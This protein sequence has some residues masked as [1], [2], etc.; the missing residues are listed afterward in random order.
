MLYKIIT[1][2]ISTE[3]LVGIH[4]ERA[5]VTGSKRYEIEGTGIDVAWK[6]FQPQT[7]RK[8]GTSNKAVVY[9]PGWG[10]NEQA[11]AI[12][13]L[14]QNLAD[15]S[16]TTT[17]AL[18]TRTES[19]I[20]HSLLLEAR[21]DRQFIEE[22]GIE[23]I[24]IVGHSQ[25]GSQAIHL[26]S[27]LQDRM[28]VNSLILLDA[29]G[30]YTQSLCELLRNYVQEIFNSAI[31]TEH[32]FNIDQVTLLKAQNKQ[33]MREGIAEIYRQMRL[34][35][36]IDHYL[37][38]LWN[39][40]TEICILNPSVQ[41]IRVPIV[42][43]HGAKDLIS[44]LSKIIP[45]QEGRPDSSYIQSIHEREQFL[46]EHLFPKSPSIKMLVAKKRGDH[47]LPA[48]RPDEVARCSLYLLE[49]SRRMK[50]PTVR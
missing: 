4:T 18:D 23:D 13:P 22:K 15:Y 41:E 45:A 20:P 11:N 3:L 12:E 49:R 50:N 8:P 19:V 17:Y 32:S 2:F 9:L 27:L 36:R 33:Y 43:I 25:G 47:G 42:I 35:E 26:T 7:A 24:T 44:Q 30:L 28:H 6:V 10:Y 14:C 29:V 21:A 5:K 48:N 31:K 39:E 38:R 34:D 37:K 40:L 46:Q 16:Q 1:G